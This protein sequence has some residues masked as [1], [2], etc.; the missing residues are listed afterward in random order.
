LVIKAVDNN[1]DDE[2][3]EGSFRGL[4]ID[5]VY[6]SCAGAIGA[7]G[8]STMPACA[9]PTDK[10]PGPGTVAVVSSRAG[11]RWFVTAGGGTEKAGPIIGSKERRRTESDRRCASGGGL[12]RPA[13][14]GRREPCRYRC[15][16]RLQQRPS[17][18]VLRHQAQPAG[19]RD[20][21]HPGPV[22][23][24]QVER[25]IG[26]RTGCEALTERIRIQMEAVRDMPDSAIALYHL[27]VN[28]TGTLP[29]LKPR[30]AELHALYRGNLRACLLQARK[31][32]CARASI[33]N[34]AS[35]FPVSAD[36]VDTVEAHFHAK[37]RFCSIAFA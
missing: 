17:G 22:H 2:S 33:S 28:S 37:L 25:R 26:G 18:A 16:G 32:S 30:I 29:E 31:M 1:D 5:P 14:H 20:R 15:R 36:D 3:V 35:W 24:R 21:Y 34:R 13:W 9:T 6:V 8:A 27:I 19:D 4:C 11:D 12:D 7:C 23:A 10:S